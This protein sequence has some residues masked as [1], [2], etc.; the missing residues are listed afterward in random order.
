MSAATEFPGSDMTGHHHHGPVAAVVP[1]AGR[2]TRFAAQS[3]ESDDPPKQFRQM[4]GKPLLV[5]TLERLLSAG[6]VE[7]VAVVV[8]LSAL[9][10]ARTL[11]QHLAPDTV[12]L[13]VVA[14]G[15]TRQASVAAGLAALPESVEL[16]V[17]HDAVR[18]LFEPVWIGATIDL[19]RDFDGALVAIPATDTLKEVQAGGSSPKGSSGVVRRTIPRSGIWQAQTPQTFRAGILRQAV[20]L[21]EK[22]GT[23]GTDEASLVEALGGTVAVVEGSPLN[24]KVTTPADW[25]YVAWQLSLAE[26]AGR[27]G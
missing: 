15:E 17:V 11:L 14:G 2:G 7:I 26:G 21:A 23:T 24:I 20:T 4:D 6:K 9:A 10:Q 8:P 1:A 22:Q 16:V 3:G 13:S 25:A 19:C 5:H 27:D 18:P 12:E